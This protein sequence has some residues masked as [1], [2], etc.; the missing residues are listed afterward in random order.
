MAVHKDGWC[1]PS[2][3]PYIT[4]NAERKEVLSFRRKKDVQTY[5][6]KFEHEVAIKIN[7]KRH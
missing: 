5:V 7:K 2:L 3:V 4:K 1:D 6:S